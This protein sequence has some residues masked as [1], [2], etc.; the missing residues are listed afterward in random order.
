MTRTLAPLALT[1]VLAGFAPAGLHAQSPAPESSAA[2]AAPTA[3]PY[4]A[5]TSMNVFRRFSGDGAK[6]LEFYGQ[7][8]VASADFEGLRELRAPATFSFLRYG[9]DV[10]TIERNGTQ[11]VVDPDREGPA[12]SF[13]VAEGDFNRRSLKGNA[14]LRWEWRAGSTL[15]LV[16]QHTRAGAA[17]LNDL[18][19]GRDLDAMFAAPSRNILAIKASYW[20]SP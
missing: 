16:W 5:E 6:T 14:V 8:F 1:F 11:L 7:P 18:R 13:T 15:F 4:F 17:D 9:R 10:G 2:A 12:R 19:L 3:R 20:F